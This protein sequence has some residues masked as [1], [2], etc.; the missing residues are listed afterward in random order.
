MAQW[1]G[2]LGFELDILADYI[3]P[4]SRRLCGSSLMRQRYPRSR[5]DSDRPRRHG[6]GLMP[7]TQTFAVWRVQHEDQGLDVVFCEATP[8]QSCSQCIV[9]HKTFDMMLTTGETWPAA[10]IC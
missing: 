1:T 3:P 2:K 8:P 9:A 10:R 7:G 4:R 5:P 6:Y